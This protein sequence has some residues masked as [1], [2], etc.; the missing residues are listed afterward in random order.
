MTSL[1]NRNHFAL[2]PHADR[3]NEVLAL[4]LRVEGINGRL[5]SYWWNIEV[6]PINYFAQP[7]NRVFHPSLTCSVQFNQRVH[8][9]HISSDKQ[10]VYVYWASLGPRT[11][12]IHV[13]FCAEYENVKEFCGVHTRTYQDADRVFSSTL[14]CFQRTEWTHKVAATNAIY[15]A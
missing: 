12:D 15:P 1:G 14:A 4:G 5:W 11:G 9:E 8:L 10:R 13:Y 6:R 2:S 7:I 3:M